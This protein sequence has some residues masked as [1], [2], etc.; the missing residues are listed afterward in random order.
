MIREIAARQIDGFH[1]I[2]FCDAMNA[3]P[4]DE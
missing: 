4:F 3:A 1:R 2:D